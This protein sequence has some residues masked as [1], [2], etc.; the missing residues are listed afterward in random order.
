MTPEEIKTIRGPFSQSIFAKCLGISVRTLQDWEC[1]R[2]HPSGPA[3]ALLRHLGKATDAPATPTT[4]TQAYPESV[5]KATD[6]P[7]PTP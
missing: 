3:R 1:G 5:G 6:A 2:R 7:P 4:P